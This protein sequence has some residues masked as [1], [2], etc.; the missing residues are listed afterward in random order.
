MIIPDSE[1]WHQSWS[2][3]RKHRK[4]TGIFPMTT[5]KIASRAPKDPARCTGHV[6]RVSTSAGRLGQF[7]EIGG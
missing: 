1:S 6:G 5:V 4:I 2:I 7:R 3:A